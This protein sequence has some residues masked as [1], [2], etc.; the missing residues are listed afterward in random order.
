MPLVVDLAMGLA[1][2]A[3]SLLLDTINLDDDSVLDDQPDLSIPDSAHSLPDA[4]QI[5]FTRG[6]RGA[7][8]FVVR[9][10]SCDVWH[11]RLVTLGGAQLVSW[12]EKTLATFQKRP[13]HPNE[14]IPSAILQVKCNI[15]YFY[16][17]NRN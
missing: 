17:T 7:N 8:S 13:R 16:R 3:K 2:S 15:Q 9:R 11:A 1:A 12:A 14:I 4:V 5:K 6:T 10:G